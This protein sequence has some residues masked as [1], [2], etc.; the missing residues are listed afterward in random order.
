ML[1]YKRNILLRSTLIGLTAVLF[2]MIVSIFLSLFRQYKSFTSNIEDIYSNL[3]S[4][5]SDYSALLSKHN[6]AENYFRLFAIDFD[7]SYFNAYKQTIYQTKTKID[8]LSNLSPFNKIESQDMNELDRDKINTEFIRLRIKLDELLNY[9][10]EI[11]K[12]AFQTMIPPSTAAAAVPSKDFTEL[13]EEDTIAEYI[14]IPKK[15]LLNRILYV[16]ER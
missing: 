7:T 8:S 6:E 10:V 14:V 2:L 9:S 13:V 12:I 5:K 16:C 15:K 4:D 3:N 1:K 11:P